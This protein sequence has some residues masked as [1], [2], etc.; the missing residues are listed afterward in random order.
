VFGAKAVSLD[1]ERKVLEASLTAEPKN[2]I[3]LHPAALARYEAMVGQLQ[4]S[5]AAGIAIGNAEYAE[6]I[7]ELVETVTVRP[8]PGPG[9]IE[10]QI[11]GRLDS[12]LGKGG[13]PR[14]AK[15]VSGST[16][17]GARFSQSRHHLPYWL[18]AAG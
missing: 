10:I 12:L 1:E 4:Q 13:Y 9:R 18:Q 11:V 8:G 7:R 14:D 6:A 17:A 5:I 15:D 16:V 3:A 2:L